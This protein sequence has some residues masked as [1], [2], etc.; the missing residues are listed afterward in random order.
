MNTSNILLNPT[1]AL[2]KAFKYSVY[3]FLTYNIF[4]F[5][6]EEAAAVVQTMTQGVSLF[7]IIEGYAATIDTAAWV[8]LLLLFELETAVLRQHTLAKPSVN[9]GFNLLRVFSYSF[10]AYAC[11]GYIS[12]VLL[13]YGISPYE[14][15]DACSLI[16]Q[17]FALVEDLDIYPMIV[18]ENCNALNGQD[19]FRLGDTSV[20]GSA[21]DFSAIQW[22]ALVDVTNSVTWM[23]V[24]ILLEADLRLGKVDKVVPYS[25]QAKV[26]L[27]SVLFACATYWGFLGDFLDFWDSFLWLVAFFF[28]EL[29][30]FKVKK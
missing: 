17:N 21:S 6:Q 2:F 22:L 15:A 7:N 29:N 5:Y 24:V 3:A 18:S 13:V 28:I 25:K 16:G 14:I 19:L 9:I 8:V 20:I 11:Y 30:I 4:L 23:L 10:I 1:E 27:Y 12:K 26:V